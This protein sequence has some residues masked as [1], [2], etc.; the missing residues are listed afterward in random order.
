MGL[1]SNIDREADAE[2]E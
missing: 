2:A 1:C